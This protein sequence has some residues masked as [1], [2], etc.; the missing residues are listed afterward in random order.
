MKFTK[1]YM[2]SSIALRQYLESNTNLEVG[3]IDCVVEALYKN[4]SDFIIKQYH[5]PYTKSKSPFNRIMFCLYAL[6]HITLIGPIKWVV[7]GEWG[8]DPRGSW[9]KFIRKICGEV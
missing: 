3:D 8:F 5:N 9:A 2:S 1:E 6:I 7:T 4:E